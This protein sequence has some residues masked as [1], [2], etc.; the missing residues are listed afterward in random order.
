[1]TGVD[2][3]DNMGPADWW[4]SESQR[5]WKPALH[6]SAKEEKRQINTKKEGLGK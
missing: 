5:R 6:P 2:E 4:T 1:M 3:Q